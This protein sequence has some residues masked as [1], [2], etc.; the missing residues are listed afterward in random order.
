MMLALQFKLHPGG[1]FL[2]AVGDEKKLEPMEAAKAITGSILSASQMITLK[3]TETIAK[4][5]TPC[6]EKNAPH[7]SRI[8]WVPG[9]A[10]G[11]TRK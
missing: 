7:A 8:L 9:T 3:M 4:N 11:R 5:H 10:N 1:V 6:L 2:K